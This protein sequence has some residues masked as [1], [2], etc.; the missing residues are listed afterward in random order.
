MTAKHTVDSIMTRDIIAFAPDTSVVT[1]ARILATRHIGGAPVVDGKGT[2]IGVVTLTD[3]A[4]PDKSKSDEEGQSIYYRIVDG[5]SEALGS[6]FLAAQKEGIVDD[7]MSPYVFS[8][9]PDTRLIDAIRLMV[10]DNIHRLMVVD[11]GHLVGIVSSMDML[12]AM[13]KFADEG[14]GL[15]E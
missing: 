8:V 3:L 9:A 1:A 7:V 5:K 11:N 15:V 2:P 10:A 12:G 13:A 14:L 4:D 6:T